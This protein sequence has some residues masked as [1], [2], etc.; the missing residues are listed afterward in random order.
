MEKVAALEANRTA[1]AAAASRARALAD[2]VEESLRDDVARCQG[3]AVQASAAAAEALRSEVQRHCKALSKTVESQ[4][5]FL[6]SIS[7][8]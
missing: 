1:T 8:H 6:L 7:S 5:P 4:T 2:A 3:A